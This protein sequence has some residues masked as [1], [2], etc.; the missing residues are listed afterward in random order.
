MQAAIS[1]EGIGKRYVLGSQKPAYKTL[2]ETLV[3]AFQAPFATRRGAAKLRTRQPPP[4]LW[5][6]K[7]VSF[8]VAPGEVLGVSGRNGCGKSTLL[9]VLSRITEPTQGSVRVRGRLGSLLEV[10][11]GFHPELTGRENVYLSGVI[12]GMRRHEIDR[13]FD[14]IIAF[15][16]VEDFVDT[17]VKRY[18]SGMYVRLAFSVA[19]HLE[20][21]ILL[22]DEVLAVGDLAFQKKCLGRI[23]E[24]SRDGR[25]VLF[26]S[27]NMVAVQ[28]LCTK[29]LLLDSGRLD[30]FG[31]VAD[32]VTRY[33]ERMSAGGPGGSSHHDLCSVRAKGSGATRFLSLSVT[34]LAGRP[35]SAI[36]VGQ[37]FRIHVTFETRQPVRDLVVGLAIHTQDEFPLFATHWNDHGQQY[38]LGE[39]VWQTSVTVAP[40][41]LRDGRYLISLGAISSTE[42]LAHIP[43]ACDLTVEPIMASPERHYDQRIGALFIPMQWTAPVSR[44]DLVA[45]PVHAL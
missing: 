15:A 11:T 36:C 21:E 12:M 45:D 4:H 9:K 30:Y 13:K 44:T 41:H 39:G 35:L 28:R 33:L 24:A 6:L 29:G 37:E 22:V 31:P 7:D 17:P 18:S 2:R 42:L 19:A 20:P 3:K 43:V 1:V 5:A 34:N 27:H 25:T 8:D 32:C 38:S 16:E 10:G 23:G 40:N 26:V 14:E